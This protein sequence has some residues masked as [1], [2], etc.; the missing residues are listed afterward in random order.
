MSS[1]GGSSSKL[2]ST[3]AT[4]GAEA[5]LRATDMSA[6]GPVAPKVEDVEGAGV[7]TRRRRGVMGRFSPLAE[8]SAGRAERGQDAVDAEGGG[9]RVSGA[10]GSS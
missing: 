7:P 10:I 3:L 5:E 4:E 8:E 6:V 1:I 9:S 2:C